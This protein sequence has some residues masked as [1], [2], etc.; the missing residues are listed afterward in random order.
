M[1]EKVN[2]FDY[3]EQITTVLGRG[4]I[5]LNTQDEKF[6]TMVIGWGHL[7]VMWNEP[8]FVAYVRDSRY[9][10]G[11]LDKTGR[12]TLSIPLDKADPEITRICGRLSGRDIDKVQEAHL[13]LEEPEVN[14]VPGVKEYPLTL[15]CEVLYT[16]KQDFDAI[17]E[18]IRERM[19]KPVE[20]YGNDIHT[21]YIAKIVSAYIIK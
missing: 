8:T 17:P 14:G 16:Q 1:K 7:G 10:K 21:A 20:H 6:N 18:T 5:L 9:T 12:F 3:A 13:T 11:P 19:Y 2:P 4:G 15:E